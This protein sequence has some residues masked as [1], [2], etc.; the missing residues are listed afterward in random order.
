MSQYSRE[1]PDEPPIH[2][3]FAGANPIVSGQSDPKPSDV[4]AV[5]QPTPEFAAAVKEAVTKLDGL[6]RVSNEELSNI[7]I[8]T[9]Q[10]LCQPRPSP[11]APGPH[12]DKCVRTRARVA[13][14]QLE[15]KE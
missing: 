7:L 1:H 2:D 10:P 15:E 12:T 11:P 5:A 8:T 6:T 4:S 3:V 14:N 13:L 9:F